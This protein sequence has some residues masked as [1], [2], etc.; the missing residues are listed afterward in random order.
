MSEKLVGGDEA[1]LL[2]TYLFVQ[3]GFKARLGRQNGHL[4]LLVPLSHKIFNYSYV[5]IDGAPH[6]IISASKQGGITVC[7]V[8]F[9]RERVASIVLSTLP[10]FA[11]RK[12]PYRTFA[13][14]NFG[15]MKASVTVDKSLI[16]FLNDC[17]LTDAWNC[18]ARAGL[19]D[20][21]KADLY[22]VL[23]K[24]ITGK[25][26]KK[27]A[28]MLL[29]FVQ[30]AFDYATDQEQFGYER[31]L[32]GDESF[33]YPKN[34][35]EDRSILYSIL[36]KD[37]LGLEAVLVQWPGHLATAV[38]FTENTDGDYFEVDGRRFTVCDPTYIGAG[39]GE[40]MPQFKGVEAKLQKI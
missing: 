8:G 7:E 15:T 20:V 16:D 33:Y 1:V 37:L 11:G 9:P 24:Q 3:S 13:A 23:K 31:P 10:S 4:V 28:A 40:T 34:D 36:V 39:V 2:Q 12:Q 32:F 5:M 29:D 26:Q 6:Y 25:S 35:C 30:T 27:A 38:A 22:P 18:Y 17:P 14:E 21:V 19:S